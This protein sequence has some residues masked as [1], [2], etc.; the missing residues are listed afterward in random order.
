MTA[1]ELLPSAKE[2]QAY[3]EWLENPMTRRVLEVVSELARPVGLPTPDPNAAL[4]HHGL[5]IGYAGM[6]NAIRSLD[7]LAANTQET[8]ELEADY[9][10][11]EIMRSIAKAK[12]E[13]GY[14]R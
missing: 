13:L 6:L 11:N 7:K 8:P 9:G 4:Y 14:G 2:V 3:R 5:F 12:K 10:A 1:S